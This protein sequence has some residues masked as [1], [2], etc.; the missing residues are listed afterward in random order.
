[1]VNGID[2]AEVHAVLPKDAIRA[3]DEPKF[4]TLREAERSLGP[5]ELVLGVALGGEARAYP[6]TILS[7]HEIVNDRVGGTAIAVTW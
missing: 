5:V 3:I 2:P 6:L 1:M 7:A 4:D